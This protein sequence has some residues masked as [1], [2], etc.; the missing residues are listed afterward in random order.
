MDINTLAGNIFYLLYRQVWEVYILVHQDAPNIMM[1]Y[2]LIYTSTIWKT[3]QQRAMCLPLGIKAYIL[4]HSVH[5]NRGIQWTVFEKL[6]KKNRHNELTHIWIL[7][8]IINILNGQISVLCLPDCFIKWP[9]W[10]H[11]TNDMI[12]NCFIFC[13]CPP[14]SLAICIIMTIATHLLGNILNI[15][16]LIPHLYNFM[17]CS[18]DFASQL[19]MSTE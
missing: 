2:D 18:A 1:I 11:L 16:K 3:H 14:I 13:C 15:D 17:I 6:S 10:R 9:I 4:P 8:L 7:L 5:V 19:T 12:W